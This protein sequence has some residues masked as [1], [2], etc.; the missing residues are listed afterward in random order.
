M[1]TR[2]ISKFYRLKMTDE[3]RD[4]LKYL[5]IKN[6]IEMRELNS[7]YSGKGEL[8]TGLKSYPVII[9]I[10]LVN[11]KIW[12]KLVAEKAGICVKCEFTYESSAILNASIL[13]SLN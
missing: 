12:I 1:D 13:K 8:V 7:I 6:M 10:G 5:P 3:I 2:I 4:V 9:N 11:K